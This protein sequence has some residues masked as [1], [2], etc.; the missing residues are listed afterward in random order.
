MARPDLYRELLPIGWKSI[1]DEYKGYQPIYHRWWYEFEISGQSR[2][3]AS[4][5]LP[6]ISDW[7]TRLATWSWYCNG[8]SAKDL[9]L[10]NM[11]SKA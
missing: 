9:Q 8:G 3:E 10:P 11:E 5:H 6:N 1:V 7:W 2:K 4:S